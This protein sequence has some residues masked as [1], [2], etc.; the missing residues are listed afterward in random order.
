MKGALAALVA[1]RDLTDAEMAGAMGEIMDG[2]AT[3]AQIGAFLA[4][5]RSKGETVEELA[6]AVRVLRERAV[7][8]ETSG[9]VIDTCGTG[10]DGLGTFNVSTA[11][12][13]VAKRPVRGSSSIRRP[14][15]A[16]STAAASR[17]C[18]RRCTIRPSGTSRPR[19]AKSAS[20][21]SST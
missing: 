12:A 16:A 2:A 10:G 5:L 3:P 18:S 13:F 14:R 7:R 19:A 21:R 20:A 15:G 9:P 11:A 8:L 6:T 17:S 1:L 4:A